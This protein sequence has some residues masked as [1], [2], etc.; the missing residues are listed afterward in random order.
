M[1][2]PKAAFLKEP[3]AKE[4]ADLVNKPAFR[5][6]ATYALAELATNL[7]PTS[8]VQMAW[9]N[10]CKLEGARLMLDTLDFLVSAEIRKP[11]LRKNLIPT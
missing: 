6:A 2:D 5:K 8:S 9:D 3:E 1:I 10:A 7:P 11:P 4:F